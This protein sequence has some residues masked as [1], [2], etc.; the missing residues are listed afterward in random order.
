M[1]CFVST[2]LCTLRLREGGGNLLNACSRG[3]RC[4]VSREGLYQCRGLL[5]ADLL[6]RFKLVNKSTR[7][8]ET[9]G[10]LESDTH[11]ILM[12]QILDVVTNHSG[13]IVYYILEC[14]RKC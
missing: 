10:T 7:L 14:F 5:L 3:D 8:Y 12:V 9:L 6:K 13:I 2:L 11:K 1:T 4:G